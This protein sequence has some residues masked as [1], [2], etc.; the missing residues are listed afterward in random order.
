MKKKILAAVLA[1][2]AA[3]GAFP[4]AALADST[5]AA[6]NPINGSFNPPVVGN[7]PSCSVVAPST[8]SVT[9]VIAAPSTQRL[10]LWLINASTMTMS[11]ASSSSNAATR[12][13]D[14]WYL[15]AASM[16]SAGTNGIGPAIASLPLLPGL[17]M[18][19]L[20]GISTTESASAEGTRLKFDG[21]GVPQGAIYALAESTGATVN[22]KAV[23]EACEITAVQ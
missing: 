2:V 19:G 20:S 7:T 15:P 9:T 22:V 8:F 12:P 5:S 10:A 21:N 3:F 11:Q 18:R 23:L 13:P 17:R 4:V 6:G 1:L 16:G 14:I